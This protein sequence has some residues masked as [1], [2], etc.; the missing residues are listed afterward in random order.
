[1]TSNIMNSTTAT[2]PGIMTSRMPHVFVIPPEEEQQEN[3]PWC[4]FDADQPP[5]DSGDC[6][7]TPHLDIHFF[8]VPYAA[9]PSQTLGGSPAI[10]VPAVDP[11]RTILATP[12]KLEKKQRPAAVQIVEK[13]VERGGCR[14]VREDSDVIEVVKVKRGKD[15]L[16]DPEEHS[17]MKRTKTLKARA[18][19]AF[20]SIKN[21]GRG[22]RKQRIKDLW[23]S[24]E[25]TTVRHQQ[26][27][28]QQPPPV[29]LPSLSRSNS[30]SLSQIFQS[31]KP[32]RPSS[33]MCPGP[34]S[35]NLPSSTPPSPSRDSCTSFT[36]N[37]VPERTSIE[38]AT[39]KPSAK[40]NKRFS[41][42][43]LHKV[44]TF[45]SSTPGTRPPTM[46]TTP[47]PPPARN[48]SV[49]SMVTSTV[50]S[51]CDDP[52]DDAYCP[53][54]FLNHRADQKLAVTHRRPVIIDDEDDY[55]TLLP[56]RPRDLSFEMRLDSL[57]FDSLSFDPEEFNVSIDGIRRR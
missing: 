7:P 13:V 18:T 33:E 31:T 17:K 42:R 3:P 26:E 20:Q 4:C 39:P 12:K 25:G 54:Q 47:P 29:M 37:L 44:F 28:L 48:D 55:G 11:P 36:K 34:A 57:H 21:V 45:P 1:M 10:C 35:Q 5:D 56:G 14:D 51:D 32:P 24:S 9:Q 22:S 19:R 30:R 52:M 8:N 38:P 50:S 2:N 46:R 27:Q 16:A 43:E 41:V 53:V 40:S 23:T 6:P 15:D 49:P